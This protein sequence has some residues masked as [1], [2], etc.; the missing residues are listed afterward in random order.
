VILFTTHY[1]DPPSHRV[2]IWPLTPAVTFREPC[3]CG[4]ARRIVAVRWRLIL[5]VARR[6]YGR[7]ALALKMRPTRAPSSNVS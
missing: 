4:R 5:G 6:A 1:F 2:I 7:A 3:H